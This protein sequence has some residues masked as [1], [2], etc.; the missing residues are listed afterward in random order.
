MVFE[1][2]KKS[3]SKYGIPSAF[4]KIGSWINERWPVAALLRLGFEEE[5]PGGAS[6]AYIFGSATLITFLLQVVT[7]ICQLF[8]YVPTI[9]HAYDSLTFLRTEVP[10]GWLIHGL[11]YWGA[12]AMVLLVGIHMVRV[13]VWGAYKQP[14][15]LT[16]LVGV[17]LLLITLGISFTGPT[18]AWDERGYWVAEVGTSI[19]G[20][21]P[22]V[23][24]LV[25]RLLRGGEIMEQ[26]TLSRFFILHI[27]ILPGILIALISVHL[28]A[29]R[30][31]GPVGPWDETQG[32]HSGPFWPDQI[33][34]DTLIATLLFFIL[35]TLAVY[36]RAP[37]T[38]P[39]DPLDTSYVPKPEWNFLFL[40][41]ALKFFPGKLEP[42]GT[43]G[44]ALFIVLLLGLLPFLDRHLECNPKKRPFAM[45]GG[46]IFVIIVLA[47]AIAGHY[48][49]GT[50]Y[51][52][53]S[54]KPVASVAHM[55]ESAREGA[56][57][58]QS[59]GCTGCH[60]V[61]GI[62]GAV[63]PDLSNEMLKGR[64]RKWL[65]TQ[66]RNPKVNDPKTIMP[67]FSS[68]TNQ[69]INALVDYLQSLQYGA[70]PQPALTPSLAGG[71]EKTASMSPAIATSVTKTRYPLG[72]PGS[73]A[74][75]MG[76]ANHGAILFK[77]DCE[78]CHGPQGTD[79]IANPGSDD[80]TVPPLNPVDRS[81]FS[82]DP[83]VFAENID[84]FIQHGS[85]PEGKNPQLHMPAFGETN[86]LTQQ[87]IS[88]IEAYVLRLNGV[89]R[90]QLAHPGIQPVHFFWLT[91]VVFGLVGLGLGTLWMRMGSRL[92]KKS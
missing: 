38:G 43:V 3:T 68:L 60:P 57:L 6:F 49:K 65:T 47:L 69:Q 66:I 72:P 92:R 27:A 39:A 10:F 35:T 84:R 51:V 42:V 67:A 55:S 9:D 62:G 58:L 45:A 25:K 87:A 86:T 8:Y 76:S 30:R 29:F 56:K 79:K 21:V 85:I 46:L 71:K 22:I 4:S 53:A 26:L 63:G 75:T 11:H 64:S 82:P 19:A 41:E 15:E 14:R 89:N 2:I 48:S 18:L 88:Q 33:L 91:V 90:A 83:R 17:S 1:F 74:A 13:F 73:A 78:S 28:I 20:T 44:I 7:G 34:Y 36:V 50:G 31:F 59:L 52:Q 77:Q 37:I 70:T 12:N 5:I 32:K 24:D 16:W 40:Y 23:G 81:L 61:N 54:S 80:E